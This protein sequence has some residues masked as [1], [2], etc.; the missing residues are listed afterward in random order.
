MIITEELFRSALHLTAPWIISLL[1]FN[2]GERR[3]DIWIDFPEGSKFPC[4]ICNTLDCPVYDTNKRTWRH[5]DFFEHQTYLHARIP[6]IKCPHCNVHQ[7]NVPWARENSGFTLLME[8]MFVLF[9]QTM[10]ISQ[11][12]KKFGLRDKQI[13]RVIEHYVKDAIEKSDLSEVTS[14]GV[15]ETS[16]RKGHEYITVFANLDTGRIIHICK[17]KDSSTLITFADSLKSHKGTL[18]Q[19]SDFCC[20]M[21]PAFI[22]GITETFPKSSIIFDKFH[23]M[24][25]VNEALDEVRRLE[26]TLNGFLKKT[27]MIWLK[28]P[29]SLTEKQKETLGTLKDMNIKTVRAYNLKLSLQGLWG[30]QDIES[31]NAYFKKWYFWATHSRIH[32]MVKVAKTIKNHWNGIINYFN[33]RFTNGLLEGLNS[34]I[35][36]LKAN[37]RGYRNDDNFMT[38]IYLRL[39]QLKFDLPT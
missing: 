8:A 28:N 12:A 24:K 16:R 19:I 27:R 38:M 15:D 20:D 36:A 17:G 21:S 29:S 11:I 30:M 14:V 22:K 7:V 37:A 4:P 2:E 3:L 9:A 5:L 33:N 26:Q 10:Q 18:E 34:L 23:V 39:G 6:R 1:K 35:Q 32:P 31:A 13:W 25:L